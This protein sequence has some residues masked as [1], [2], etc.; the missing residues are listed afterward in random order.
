MVNVF[1]V[2][3]SFAAMPLLVVFVDPSYLFCDNVFLLLSLCVASVCWC[4]NFLGLFMF[5]CGFFFLSFMLFMQ[6]FVLLSLYVHLTDT[7]RT[8]VVQTKA[9]AL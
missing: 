6:S 5:F 7:R 8:I 4:N 3:I 1:V 9:L 2:F